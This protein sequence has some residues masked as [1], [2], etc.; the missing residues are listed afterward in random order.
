MLLV[1]ALGHENTMIKAKIQRRCYDWFVL[2]IRR[3]FGLDPKV[4]LS[5]T[6]TVNVQGKPFNVK[7]QDDEDMENFHSHNEEGNVRFNLVNVTALPCPG[8][9]ASTKVHILGPADYRR[10][11]R[12]T[13][14]F[15]Q[16]N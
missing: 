2:K 1:V 7:L 16:L 10:R 3:K 6:Y 8:R 9:I 11:F 12:L 15:F 13:T 5:L 4:K 14:K